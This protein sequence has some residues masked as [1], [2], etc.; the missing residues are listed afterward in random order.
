LRRTSGDSIS[1]DGR[2]PVRSRTWSTTASFTL[3]A[4]NPECV[5]PGVRPTASTAIVV[6]A[7]RCCSHSTAATPAYRSSAV[8]AGKLASVSKMRLASRD[9]RHARYAI[10][11]VPENETAARDS[12]TSEA[13]RARSSSAR[14]D[15]MPMAH[16]AISV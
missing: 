3:S 13:P 12:R 4:A 8:I 11:S 15:S 9:Q 1:T 16:V 7:E 14:S 10:S 6:S 2:S 5:I